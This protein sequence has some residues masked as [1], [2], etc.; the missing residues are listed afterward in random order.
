MCELLG[1]CFNEEVT[2]SISFRGFRQ[3]GKE[4]KD[5]WE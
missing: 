1:M 3:R 4:N 2:S 5:G